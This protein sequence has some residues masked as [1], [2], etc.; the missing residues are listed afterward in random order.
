MPEEQGLNFNKYVSLY[1]I[2]Q[3]ANR[4]GIDFELEN[5]QTPFTVKEFGYNERMQTII[6][7][8]LSAHKFTNKKVPVEPWWKFW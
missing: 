4:L 3:L 7:K 6:D 8:R 2:S 5:T 1:D